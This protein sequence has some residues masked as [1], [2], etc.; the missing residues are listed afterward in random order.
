V[1]YAR[2]AQTL[3]TRI[4]YVMTARDDPTA[5]GRIRDA[6][7]AEFAERGVAAATIRGIAR[8][9]GVSPA[10]VQ[11]HFSTKEN[12]REAC[13]EHAMRYL[14]NAAR[15]GLDEGRIDDPDHLRRLYESTPTVLR[16]LA[17]ALVDGSE[18][19]ART[20]DEMV[21]LTEDRLA[22]PEDGL[23]DPHDRAVVYTA[24]RLGVTVLHEHVSRGLG[25]DL[26]SPEVATRAGLA[27]LD[28]TAPGIVP[29]GVAKRARTG[30]DAIRS[31]DG[32]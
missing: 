14:G 18:A 27:T 19:A 24:M 1:L 22:D 29:D 21:R 28:V 32:R 15:E 16:Y 26:F 10:L 31:E 9:A 4:V 8:R 30:I 25:G 7:L 3:Y 12:L 13:D 23:A 11:H 17:R 2:I 20:F 5:R 6:A